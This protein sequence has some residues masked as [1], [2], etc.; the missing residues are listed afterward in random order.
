MNEEDNRRLWQLFKSGNWEAF[1]GIYKNHFKLLNNYGH[2]FSK[3][4]NLV[5]DAVH[6]L[7]VKLWT[8]RESLG[9]PVSV[10]NYLYKAFRSIIFKKM[11]SQKMYDDIDQNY[12]FTVESPLDFQMIANEELKALQEKIK[13]VLATLPPRQQEIIFLRFY[14]GL[15]YEEISGIMSLSIGSTYKLLYKALHKLSE[16][17]KI[18]RFVVFVLLLSSLKHELSV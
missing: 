1:S 16:T 13:E 14:E 10:K 12:S 11:K 9:D 2:K 18:S 7:F 6:D 15:S 17:L 4:V 3:D 5:E 8:N